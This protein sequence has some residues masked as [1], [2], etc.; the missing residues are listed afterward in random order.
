M[1]LLVAAMAAGMM[2]APP[3]VSS[4]AYEKFRRGKALYHFVQADMSAGTVSAKA[5]LA[6][7]LTSAWTMIGRNQPSVAITG[8]FFG[9]SSG[10]PVGDVLING[11]LKAHGQRGSAVG[12]DWDGDVEIFDT[13]FLEPVEWANYQ[14]GLRGAVRLITDGVIHPNP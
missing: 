4:I 7:G 13:R 1:S 6:S 9:P 12:V 14:W 5:V 2:S 10:Y 8:T 11:E 3:A